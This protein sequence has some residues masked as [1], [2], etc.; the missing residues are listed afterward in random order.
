MVGTA[1]NHLGW[2]ATMRIRNKQSPVTTC[3]FAIR[4]HAEMAYDLLLFWKGNASPKHFNYDFAIYPKSMKQRVAR[5][6]TRSEVQRA[7]M[8]LRAKGEF[9][10]LYS[11]LEIEEEKSEELLSRTMAD[12]AQLQT[13]MDE[14][15]HEMKQLEAGLHRASVLADEN[16]MLRRRFEDLQASVDAVR[17]CCGSLELPCAPR[18]IECNF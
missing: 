3:S 11:R 13:E 4:E 2:R 8:D 5:C 6:H 12:L 1:R 18:F 7:I 16:R 9:E 15:R 17:A 10:A 14:M